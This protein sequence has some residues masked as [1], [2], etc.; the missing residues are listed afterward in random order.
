VG[1]LVFIR[2]CIQAQDGNL[3]RQLPYRVMSDIATL[4]DYE[5]QSDETSKFDQFASEMI[6]KKELAC[7]LVSNS[8]PFLSLWEQQRV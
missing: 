8:P 1:D 4:H 3:M 2:P 7:E 6:L 5:L